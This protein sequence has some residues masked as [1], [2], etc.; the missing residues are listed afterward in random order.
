MHRAQ[1]TSGRVSLLSVGEGGSPSE[2][3]S[4]DGKG[5]V[6][7]L[8][9]NRRRNRELLVFSSPSQARVEHIFP[10]SCVVNPQQG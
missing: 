7:E 3:V 4:K 2:V 9:G 10:M 1:C 5:N 6:R 8:V